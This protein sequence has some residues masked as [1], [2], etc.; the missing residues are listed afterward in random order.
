[1]HII[2]FAVDT[3]GLKNKKTMG[4]SRIKINQKF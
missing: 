4:L 1:M 2:P 3:V